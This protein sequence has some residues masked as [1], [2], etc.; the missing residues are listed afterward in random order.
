MLPPFDE[1]AELMEVPECLLRGARPVNEA[2]LL[3]FENKAISFE[4][5]CR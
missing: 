3:W 1:G 4:A 5:R 2:C